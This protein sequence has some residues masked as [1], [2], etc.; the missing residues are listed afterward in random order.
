MFAVSAVSFNRI[1]AAT[2][3]FAEARHIGKGA[4][5]DVYSAQIEDQAV[6][7]KLLNL[8]EAATLAAKAALKRTF[9]RELAVLSSYR[10]PRLV[11]LQHF[12]E[13][14]AAESCH[15]FALIFELLEGGSL[16]DWLRGPG[17]EPARRT[18]AGGRPLTALQR[19]DIAL[20]AAS[21]AAFLHGQREVDHEDA[22]PAAGGAGASGAPC[23]AFAAA[24]GAA[25]AA[26]V[27]H[28]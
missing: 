1:R 11:R 7:V 22:A 13:D 10:N 26:P 8:P 2:D 25:T 20:G 21:G 18:H 4:T 24:V 27:L 3:N 28:R 23:P 6:A 17:G 9:H 12:A 19:V 15:P 5:G 14:A 16:A